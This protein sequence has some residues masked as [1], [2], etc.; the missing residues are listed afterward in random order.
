M[1]PL[2]GVVGGR[3]DVGSHAVRSL[4][5]RGCAHKGQAQQQTGNTGG[6]GLFGQNTQTS[7][8]TGGGLFG[9]ST[10][11]N[12][13]TGTGGGLFGGGGGFPSHL[14]FSRPFNSPNFCKFT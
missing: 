8:N 10:T 7:T 3:G 1:S 13:T 4:R 2:V 9:Q 11:Q 14:N 12:Q 6:S 5:G